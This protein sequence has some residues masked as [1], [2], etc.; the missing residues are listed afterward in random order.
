MSR[1]ESPLRLALLMDPLEEGWP[2]MDLAGEALHQQFH[3]PLAEAVYVTSMRPKLLPLARKLPVLRDRREALN[4]DRVLTR[5]LAYPARTALGRRGQD[6]WHV[7]DHTYAQLVHTLPPG[8]AGVYCHD[9]DAFRSIL[10]P[11][12]ERR[13]AWFKAM[14]WTTLKGLQR[15]AVVFH[16]TG[17]VREELLRHGVVPAERL[18]HAPLGVSEEYGPEPVPGDTSDEVLR[19]LGGRPYVLHVGS[20][21]PRKR[22]DVLFEVFAAMRRQHP[23]LRLVQQGAAL[24]EAQLAQV[25]RLGIGDALL[26]PAKLDRATLAGLYRKAKAVLVTSESEGFGLPVIEALACGTPVVASDI[27]VLREVGGDAANYAAVGNT[28][29][30]TEAVHGVLSAPESDAARSRRIERGRGYSWTNH[31]RIILDTY[32][33]L[34]GR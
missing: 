5:F 16:S 32:R 23:D 33:R 18:V 31:A 11:Y 29:A 10:E 17:A 7:V 25:A 34:A 24:N 1:T 2:S 30:W 22:L 8:R 4:V 28:V 9:L 26:Q 14:A 19:P 12:K 27:P 3:G 6:A 13:P 21:I 20:G 15:A